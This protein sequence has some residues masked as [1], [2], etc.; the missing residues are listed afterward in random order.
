MIRRL[1]AEG[2]HSSRALLARDICSRFGFVD[3]RGRE[4][5]A[6]CVRPFANW[7]TRGTSR[8]PLLAGP[9]EP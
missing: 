1:L 6:G 7:R 8:T 5:I 9:H 2:V 4:Q 3:A